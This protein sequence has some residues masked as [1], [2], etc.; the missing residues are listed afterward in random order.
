MKSGKPL[1]NKK[2]LLEK[3]PGKGGWTYAVI[4]E[5][6]QNKKAPF[7]WVKVKGTIDGSK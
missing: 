3:Y 7:G 5:V 4:P 1:V 6:L 2:Y